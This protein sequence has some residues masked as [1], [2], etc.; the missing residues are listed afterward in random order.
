[1]DVL[2]IH[3]DKDL[4]TLKGCYTFSNKR[5]EEEWDWS[6]QLLKRLSEARKEQGTHLEAKIEV[7]TNS[8]EDESAIWTAFA[9]GWFI[10]SDW[11]QRHQRPRNTD[12]TI[13]GVNLISYYAGLKDYISYRPTI[14]VGFL[15]ND[16]DRETVERA[17]LATLLP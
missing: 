1:M 12:G 16:Q 7:F 2:L 17:A 4:S 13:D 8:E 5:A 9:W 15:K 11:H 6:I 10:G 14:C 3:N